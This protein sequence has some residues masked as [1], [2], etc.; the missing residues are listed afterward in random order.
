MKLFAIIKDTFRELLVRKVLVGFL[1][2]NAL[3]LAG[4]AVFISNNT[5]AVMITAQK[6]VM[7]PDDYHAL[8]RKLIQ[9]EKFQDAIQP[10]SEALKLDPRLATAFNARGYC[11]SRL[12][13]YKEAIADFDQALK[14]NSS[15]TNAYTN[16]A[17]AR[18][19][20]G[21]KAGAD[22]DMAKVRELLGQK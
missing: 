9:E 1:I 3:A 16:R 13:R 20:A 4:I 5:V 15:Y 11:Y 19:A 18:R 8:G 22:A 21:D 2:F 14:L 7:T 10:L 17:A 6:Q 12:R